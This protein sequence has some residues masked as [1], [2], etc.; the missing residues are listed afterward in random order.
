MT[1]Q[2]FR[3]IAAAAVL[4][5]STPLL[6]QATPAP[7]DAPPAPHAH[8]GE[9]G[10]AHAKH[11]HV[12]HG[13]MGLTQTP[14]FLRGIDLDE[15]QR[16]KVFQILHQRA[17]AL[18]DAYKETHKARKELRQLSA[19]NSFDEAR[20]RALTQ[21]SAKAMAEAQFLQARSEADIRAVLTTEQRAELQ[22]RQQRMVE[23]HK[24]RQSRHDLRPNQAAALAQPS[25]APAT[26]PAN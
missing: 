4:A 1:T 22:L 19:S 7:T 9:G 10:P 5:L 23:R 3:R 18:R 20:A 26:A 12:R 15:A 17:P 14:R 6:V 25:Q 8:R 13:D 11:R 24:Q 2:R 16:D 21:Q